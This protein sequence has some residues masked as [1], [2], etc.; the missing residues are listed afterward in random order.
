MTYSCHNNY[1]KMNQKNIGD[2]IMGDLDFGTDIINVD[3][4][5]IDQ[6]HICCANADKKGDDSAGLKKEWLKERFEDGL[7]FKRLNIRGKVFIEYIPAEKAWCPVNAPD[8]M[9][10]NCFWVSGQFKGHGYGNMLL[11]QCILDSKT[12]GKKG[13]VVV[14]SNKKMPFLSDP[15]YLKYKG[16][17]VCDKAAP[18]FEL[19]ALPFSEDTLL[20]SFKQCAKSA[21]IEEKGLVL[22]YTNQCPYAQKYAQII[23]KIA[24]ERGVNFKMIKY[25]T[26]QQAQ[27]APSPFTTY[28]LFCD[29]KFVTNEILSDKKFIKFLDENH[30]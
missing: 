11:E 19:L 10:I 9:F 12:K 27:Q 21:E 23:E 3:L 24:K 5:N 30:L 17:K 20:P 22:Y 1:G 8:Y 28:S 26:T 2:G 15:K 14:S 25:Q 16:F 4:S 29:G 13:L 6:E 7:V 18:Y